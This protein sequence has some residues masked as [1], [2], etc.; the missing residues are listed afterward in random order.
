MLVKRGPDVRR[1]ASVVAGALV[2]HGCVT[3]PVEPVQPTT[4][5]AHGWISVHA[6]RPGTVIAAPHGTS[7]PR[8]GEIAAEVARRTGFGLVV[9]SGFAVEPDAPGTPGRRYQ[10][11]RPFEGVPGKP[12]GDEV[13]TDAARQVYEMY[14]QRVRQAAQGRLTFYA[15][16]HGNNRR[17]TADRIEIATVGV[18]R[19]EAGRLRTLLELCRDAHLRS[20]PQA[21][22]LDARV[23]PADPVVYAASGAKRVGILRLPGR[24][25][26]IELP[27]VARREWIEMYTA[28]LADFLAQAAALPPLR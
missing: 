17:D 23:E 8:T 21:P 7:D 24:A 19:D 11:N 2:L 5:G 22:R 27:R 13:A 14:E 25:L 15:E 16:I 10:V 20:H 12:P 28:I 9:A 18:D 1:V 4:A 6:G 26:H 3:Y